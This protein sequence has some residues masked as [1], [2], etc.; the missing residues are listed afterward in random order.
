MKKTVLFLLVVLMLL[1]A[2]LFAGGS[3]EKA[4][5]GYPPEMDAW[6]KEAKLGKY[7]KKQ[8]W[9]EIIE[10]AKQEGNVIVYASSSRIAGMPAEE[11]RKNIS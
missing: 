7:D 8:D 1:P 5:E 4:G 10:K 11:F 9:N 2:A 3:K 6:A